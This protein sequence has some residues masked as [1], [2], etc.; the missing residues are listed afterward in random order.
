MEL[1]IGFIL[2]LVTFQVNHR[3]KKIIDIKTTINTL[4]EMYGNS[5]AYSTYPHSNVDQTLNQ[6]ILSLEKMHDGN[7]VIKPEITKLLKLRMIYLE[8]G[9]LSRED[10]ANKYNSIGFSSLGK[11]FII[12]AYLN[13]KL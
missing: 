7:I 4:F 3:I 6:E 11:G 13:I 2:A 8:S 10:F 1:F 9:D 12:L 5:E